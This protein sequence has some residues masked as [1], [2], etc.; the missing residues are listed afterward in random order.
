EKIKDFPPMT[1]YKQQP[2]YKNPKYMCDATPKT[3]HGCP[4]GVLLMLGVM[5]FQLFEQ[6]GAAKVAFQPTPD[7]RICGSTSPF[8]AD[9]LVSNCRSQIQF[10]DYITTSR[11]VEPLFHLLLHQICLGV[12]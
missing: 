7:A 10:S 4:E 8:F 3:I 5:K 9:R 2:W 11:Y 12:C 6:R 1:N